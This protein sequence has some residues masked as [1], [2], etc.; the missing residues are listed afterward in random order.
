MKAIMFAAGCMVLA[1]AVWATE[2]RVDIDNDVYFSAN[3]LKVGDTSGAYL[4]IDHE[5]QVTVEGE[6]L[7]LTPEQQLAIESYKQRL[8]EYGPRVKQLTDDGL[9]VALDIIDEVSIAMDAPRAFDDLKSALADYFGRLQERYYSQDGFSVPAAS[10]DELIEQWQQELE[11]AKALF[12]RE[13]FED[14]FNALS[15]KMN[16]EGG[17]NLTQMAEEMGELK[18]QLEQ[19]F[20]EHAN[21][22]KK[23]K[24]SLCDELEGM[25]QQEQELHQKIPQL[26]NY[27]VFTI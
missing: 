5:D 3:S 2:C 16:Q 13:F 19:K 9:S 1:P 25:K 20:R 10:F 6:V 11:E 18:G 14:A 4:E 21:Q 8:A 15:A 7:A 26:K 22:L 17:L 24:D 23:D 12:T 27:R